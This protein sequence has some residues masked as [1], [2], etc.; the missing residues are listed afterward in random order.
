[1]NNEKTRIRFLKF[2]DGKQNL[3]FHWP[4]LKPTWQFRFCN[5]HL[6]ISGTYIYSAWNITVENK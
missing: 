6:D 5:F 1:M 3:Q 2:L 4:C